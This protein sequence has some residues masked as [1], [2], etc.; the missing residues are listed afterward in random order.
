MPGTPLNILYESTNLITTITSPYPGRSFITNLTLQI[1]K[2]T[3]GW[4]VK[5]LG[6]GH[7]ASV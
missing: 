4:E 7:G 6:K 5:P 2:L 1:T 3:H